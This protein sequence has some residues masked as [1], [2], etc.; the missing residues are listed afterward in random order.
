[1]KAKRTKKKTS[2]R[3]RPPLLG[4]RLG[5]GFGLRIPTDTEEQF[6]ELVQLG[7]GG[8]FAEV[9]RNIIL[10]GVGRV[11]ARVRKK[12]AKRT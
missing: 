6:E 11:L 5:E 2:D 1:M 8:T 12:K 7:Y 4:K 9:G 3:G 10:E